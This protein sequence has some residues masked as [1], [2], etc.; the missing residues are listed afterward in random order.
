MVVCMRE[1]VRAT[2]RPRERIEP[3]VEALQVALPSLPDGRWVRHRGNRETGATLGRETGPCQPPVGKYFLETVSLSPGQNHARSGVCP[4]AA[5][6]GG[7]RLR[8]S[9]LC[10]AP[11]RAREAGPLRGHTAWRGSG[12][13]SHRKPLAE[14]HGLS[15]PLTRKADDHTML[16]A[17]NY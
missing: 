6:H 14:S 8:L 4:E 3:S 10:E 16:I 7:T 13:R 2:R 12:H 9:H 17:S 11:M 1:E 5:P 15:G